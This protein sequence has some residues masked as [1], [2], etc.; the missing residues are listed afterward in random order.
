MTNTGPV[1]SGRP[2]SFWMS[3]IYVTTSWSAS[4]SKRGSTFTAC[5]KMLIDATSELPMLMPFAV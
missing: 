4:H 3:A 2:V 5:S 1:V